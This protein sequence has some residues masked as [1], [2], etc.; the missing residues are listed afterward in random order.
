MTSPRYRLKQFAVEHA[1]EFDWG[2]LSANPNAIHL[3]EQNLDRVNWGYLSRNPNAIHL[4]EQ[5]P[6]NVDWDDRLSTNPSIFE[7][8]YGFYTERCN[9]FKEELI[10]E[11]YRPLRVMRYFNE[12][13]Y[14]V[15]N[16][17]YNAFDE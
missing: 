5:N 10:Q 15:H 1:D 13:N 9:V 17:V 3:L 4:L 6:D 8:D 11:V 16:D 12:Y 7:I 14:D 2:I